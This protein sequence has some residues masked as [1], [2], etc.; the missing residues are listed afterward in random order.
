MFRIAQEDPDLTG[1]P[2]DLVELIQDCL[3]KDP[4]ARPST[5]DVLERLGETETAETWLPGAL[6]AQLGRQAVG[7]LDVEDP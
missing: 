1:I 7:L 6:T 3:T 2:V 5:D 4:G